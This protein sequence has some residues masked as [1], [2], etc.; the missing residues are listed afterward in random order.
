[1]SDNSLQPF[2]APTPARTEATLFRLF[3]EGRSAST[4]RAYR[5]DVEDLADFLST[6]S[7][8]A[9]KGLLSNGVGAANELVL[10][11]RNNLMQRGMKPASVNR[12]MATIRSLVAFARTVGA[13]DFEI[14]VRGVRSIPYRDTRGPGTDGVRG[15]LLQLTRRGDDK[16]ARDTALIRLMFDLALRCSEVVTL[17]VAH[18]DLATFCI[19]VVRKGRSERERLT[20]P[21]PTAR[22]VE[23]W[24][25]VR[26][27][28]PGPLFLNFDRAGK[29]HRLTT[30]GVYRIVRQLG[31]QIGR[32]V[33]PHGLR[34]AAVTA[35]LTLTNGDVR[36]V[37]K[38]SSHRSIQTVLI[39]DDNRSDVA[40]DVARLVAESI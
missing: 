13:V 12:R 40:G 28:D 3:L 25:A 35:A 1:M 19:H 26:R 9:I 18:V 31:L 15:M 32:K 22:S 10:R 7:A 21:S 27:S 34:H 30:N 8:S 6:D 4:I 39:Y 37:A 2:S 24:L 14:A 29:G 36:T 20:L 16:A 23:A 33:R 38:F 5:S 11:Y 17:D